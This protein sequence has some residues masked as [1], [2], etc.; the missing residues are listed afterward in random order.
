MNYVWICN[1]HCEIYRGCKHSIPLT[2]KEIASNAFAYKCAI[3]NIQR[4]VRANDFSVLKR[5]RTSQSGSDC[6]SF[7]FC[8]PQN[9]ISDNGEIECGLLN[10][11]H[12][13]A[14]RDGWETSHLF[15]ISHQSSIY[16]SNKTRSH[17]NWADYSKEA[18]A[19][20]RRILIFPCFFFLPA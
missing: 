17:W 7:F 13:N 10:I 4:I 15:R 1:L 5:R 6:S 19:A 3:I 9:V 18:H 2:Q 14:S 16:F 11:I 8:S 12:R 20:N